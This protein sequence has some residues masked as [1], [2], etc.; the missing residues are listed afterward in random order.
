[1]GIELFDATNVRSITSGNSAFN[2]V[3]NPVQ[4]WPEGDRK[5]GLGWPAILVMHSEDFSN[6]LCCNTERLRLRMNVRS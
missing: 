6:P 2:V 1:M 3:Q 4:K 5:E